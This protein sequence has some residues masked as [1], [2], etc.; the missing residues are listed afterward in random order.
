MHSLN[1]ELFGHYIEFHVDAVHLKEGNEILMSVA[2]GL[3]GDSLGFH[4]E[5]SLQPF[6][7][8]G[9]TEFIDLLVFQ[10]V[11]LQILTHF[12]NKGLHLNEIDKLLIDVT[13]PFSP[14]PKVTLEWATFGF[15]VFS[16]DVT[17][18]HAGVCVFLDGTTE[19]ELLLNALNC[20]LEVLEH[21]GED[22]VDVDGIH[23]FE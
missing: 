17:H 10:I 19:Q 18:G 4:F 8:K 6:L 23:L 22:V 15:S 16:F 9:A 2:V 7:G 21:F 12:A 14:Q 20:F 1:D 3:K 13:A 5:H 11:F